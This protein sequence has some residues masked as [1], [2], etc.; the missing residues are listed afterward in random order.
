M[1]GSHFTA[2][3]EALALLGRVHDL[4][5]SST[6]PGTVRGHHYHLRRDAIVVLPGA[7]WWMPWDEGLD[8]LRR[9]SIG[10]L[11]VKRQFSCGC[12]WERR[13]RCVIEDKTTLWLV[14]LSSES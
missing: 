10:A 7:A 4:D 1:R 6:E 12:R 8:T 5:L 2:P 14:A 11:M 3:S 9:R 13:T